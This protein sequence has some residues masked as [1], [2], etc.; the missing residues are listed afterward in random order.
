MRSWVLL[1]VRGRG[2]LVLRWEQAH[3]NPRRKRLPVDEQLRRHLVSEVE[4]GRLEPH[5]AGER[6]E[7][8]LA[9]HS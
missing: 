9:R 2:R 8:F 5:E 7:R 1:V 6:Y 3:G 4:Q